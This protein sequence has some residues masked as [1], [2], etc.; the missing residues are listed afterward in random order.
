MAEKLVKTASG[1]RHLRWVKRIVAHLRAQQK[2]NYLLTTDQQT[3]VAAELTMIEPLVAA[4]AD[5]V[6]PYRAFVEEAYVELHAAQ[7]IADYLCDEGQRNA[8]G[9]LSPRRA[10]LERLFKAEGGFAA[11]FSKKPLS[12]VLRAGRE[13]TE[14]MAR[15]GAILIGSIPKTIV[16]ATDVAAALM[17]AADLFK[18]FLTEEKNVVDPQRKPLKLAVN[19]AVYNLREGL[20]QMDGR[21]RSHFADAFIDSLY[22]EL[23]KG[24]AAVAEEDDEDA[25]TTD[26]PANPAPA[27]NAGST[28][29]NT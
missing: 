29:T 13:A 22:P 1:L 11:I 2:H 12:R 8:H 26:A 3:A 25:D 14:A 18:G 27:V 19:T 7:A 16:D 10:E 6:T 21:L 9:K 15:T 24:G 28:T 23:K 4:L 17:Q 5:A 20:D